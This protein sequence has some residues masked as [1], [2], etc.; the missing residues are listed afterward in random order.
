[1]KYFISIGDFQYYLKKHYQI[2]HRPARM[3]DMMLSLMRQGA[4]KTEISPM[5][6]PDLGDDFA[7]N[8]FIQLWDNQYLQFTDPSSSSGKNPTENVIIPP[9]QDIADLKHF[10]YLDNGG[11]H[12]HDFFEMNYVFQGSCCFYFKEELHQMQEGELCLIAPDSPHDI[13]VSD[14]N[15]VVLTLAVRKSTFQTA[16]GSLLSQNDLISLFFR[17][18]FSSDAKPNYL[19]FFTGQ[20]KSI[21]TI[22]KNLLLEL[23]R[24]DINNTC[25]ISWMHLLLTFVLRHHSDTVLYDNFQANENFS[26]ILHYIRHHYQNLTL[27]NLAA[28][29]H[30]TEPYLSSLI[31]NNTGKTY[32]QLI[33]EIRIQQAKKYLQ[34]TDLKIAEIAERIGYH[35]ADHFTN[36]FCAEMGMPPSQWRSTKITPG[37]M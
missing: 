22:L 15:S 36:T 23:W 8:D 20:Q 10:R 18:N 2:Y 19:L 31:K 32:T 12:V 25:C 11:L 35:S 9:H 16:F 29:F 1:M 37:K 4:L 24:P 33:K 17:S 27:K 34:N 5:P 7:E 13:T 28:F 30:Y 3:Q 21:R 26:L 6:L 14:D